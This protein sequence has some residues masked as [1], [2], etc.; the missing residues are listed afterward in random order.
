[1]A[2]A[3]SIYSQ[4]K[5]WF[6]KDPCAVAA[7]SVTTDPSGGVVEVREGV[8]GTLYTLA[9]HPDN[10]WASAES[11]TSHFF[12][13]ASGALAVRV[14]RIGTNGALYWGTDTDT[15]PA[16]AA[17]A[18]KAEI[19]GLQADITTPPGTS[20]RSVHYLASADTGWSDWEVFNSSA[21]AA[22]GMETDNVTA[23]TILVQ[24]VE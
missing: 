10:S 9:L 11:D 24:W 22:I 15:T 4:L 12:E 13:F 16:T 7:L 14:K 8:A 6:G 19:D 3:S 23:D 17:T 1:M 5:E 2:F 20:G 21:I 18:I